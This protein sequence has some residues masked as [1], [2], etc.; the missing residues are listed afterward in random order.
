MTRI[1]TYGD[2]S[3]ANTGPG[4]QNVTYNAYGGPWIQA[5][6]IVVV[7][8][9]LVVGIST[10][11]PGSGVQRGWYVAVLAVCAVLCAMCLWSICGRSTKP[12]GKVGALALGVIACATLSALFHQQL[13]AHGDVSVSVNVSGG[14]SLTHKAEVTAAFDATPARSHLR[15]RAQL[16]DHYPRG[17]CAAAST[18]TVVP[19]VGGAPQS[20][21]AVRLGNGEAGDI[22]LHGAQG[23][24]KLQ[25]VVQAEK[26][27]RL[28]LRFVDAVLYDK[29]GWLP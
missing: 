22:D 24:V 17:M 15:L 2:N 8:V 13:S 1:S 6:A 11:P 20:G 16:P 28:D 10:L 14:G 19:V 27:C 5:V 21:D 7:V 25:A 12:L 26:G 9:G 29:N 23:M 4:T 3:A 18:V